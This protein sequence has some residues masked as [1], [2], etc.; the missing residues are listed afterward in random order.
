MTPPNSTKDF[1]QADTQHLAMKKNEAKREL[2]SV[3]ALLNQKVEA[4]LT[5]CEALKSNSQFKKAWQ[6]CDMATKESPKMKRP[7]P[8]KRK[9]SLI[10]EKK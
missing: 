4:L 1:S 5:E 8:S 10:S 3:K 7:T 6:I 9:R 2:A